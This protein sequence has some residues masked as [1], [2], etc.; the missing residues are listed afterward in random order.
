MRSRLSKYTYVL[1]SLGLVACSG[2]GSTGTSSAA[3]ETGATPASGGV[4]A[5]PGS[6]ML[7]TYQG[8][9][10]GSS[11]WHT[12]D[13]HV[14]TLTYGNTVIGRIESIST[15]SRF[16][17]GGAWRLGP[18]FTV[19]RLNADTDGS[20]QTTYVPSILLDYERERRLFQFEV[21]GQLGQR[22]AFLQLS[23][24]TFVQTQ[25]TTR[26]YVSVSYRLSFQ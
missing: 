6:G 16:P 7:L 4:A 15:N 21:G 23:N 5:I 19:N 25:N 18:R 8:Q 9:L 13:F 26:Y 24:G 10:Y 22:E 17:I 3:T 11:L 2:S 20:T 14:V 1:A 12:G